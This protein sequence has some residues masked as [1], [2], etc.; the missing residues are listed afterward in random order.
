MNNISSYTDLPVGRNY[1]IPN[2]LLDLAFGELNI[3]RQEN[4]L[5]VVLTALIDPSQSS[6]GE[7]WQTGVALD[8]SASMKN[9]YGAN[10]EFK[11][12]LNE[13]EIEQLLAKGHATVKIV[14]GQKSLSFTSEGF[15]AMEA[16][17][18]WQKSKNEIEVIARNAIPYLA[19]KLDE[20]GGT[21][22]IYWACGSSGERIEV[23]GDL[24][25]AEAASATYAG[26][27]EWGDG[28]RLMPAI[29]H[30]LELF[31]D[32]K[33]GF[34][35]FVTDGAIDDFEEVKNFTAQLSRDIDAKS[36]NPVK[37][38]LIGVG[39]QINRQQLE[40][41]DDLPDVMD[42]PYDVWDHKIAVEM[43]GLT[44]IF[45][46]LVDENLV[47]APS[48]RILDH[49]KSVAKEY[50]DGVPALME[51]QLPLEATHFSLEVTGGQSVKQE[52][53]ANGGPSPLPNGGPPPLPK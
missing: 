32:A 15:E 23:V 47:L 24:T 18:L 33:M 3:T 19:E 2:E 43:R 35:I 8:G 51:F 30:F 45:A 25:A 11:R 39:D 38:V 42:L 50:S 34:Y 7:N 20:D 48:G 17:G 27:T 28:T 41:L 6:S 44:D 1:Q 40:D 16:E 37:L 21:T 9:A 31:S 13:Q 46:E 26:P 29:N 10:Y 49:Q 22:L 14:D 52:I 53:Y 36:C 5:E 4:C 12:V